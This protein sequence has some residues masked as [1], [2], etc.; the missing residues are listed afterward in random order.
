MAAA[1]APLASTARL[2]RFLCSTTTICGLRKNTVPLFYGGTWQ[3]ICSVP[4]WSGKGCLVA[5]KQGAT[6]SLQR[7]IP[8]LL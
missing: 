8:G 1:T 3:Q 5:I 7:L 6:E 4:P 2:P